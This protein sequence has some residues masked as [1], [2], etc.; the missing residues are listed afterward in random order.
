MVDERYI[1]LV[2]NVDR[3]HPDAVIGNN[4]IIGEGTVI[5]EG[6]KIGDNVF[7]GHFGVFRAGTTIGND[8]KLSHYVSIEEGGTVGNNVNMG[9]RSHLTKNGIIEDWVFYAF[10]V[11]CL[12]TRKIAYGRNYDA[13][14]E[15][16]IIRYGARIGARTLIM[17]GVEIGREVLIGASSLVTRNCKPFGVYI[18]SPAKFVR[19]VPLE[20]RL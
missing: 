1:S 17:P 18:G 16:S 7:I 10:D 12:N 19:E 13:R 15:P 20:E 14:F 2:G 3:I 6:C 5:E 11:A 8:S 9:I 4:V